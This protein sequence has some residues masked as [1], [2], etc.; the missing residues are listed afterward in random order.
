M[1]E[2]L[3]NDARVTGVVLADG[4]RF[5]AKAIICTAGTFLDGLIHIGLHSF[6]GGR[7][8]EPAAVGLSDS[9]R[10]LGLETARLKTGTPARLDRDSI[11]W[12]HSWGA[13]RG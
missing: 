11:N 3:T 12:G 1:R 13:T 2:I 6:P 8:G 10:Q 9:F 7:D 4:T 5:G